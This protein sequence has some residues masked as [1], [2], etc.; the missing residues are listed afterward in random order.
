[1]RAYATWAG[2]FRTSHRYERRAVPLWEYRGRQL[3]ETRL[4]RLLLLVAAAAVYLIAA[5]PW[6]TAPW[7]M[8]AAKHQPF[9][10]VSR[11]AVVVESSVAD[12]ADSGAQEP[13]RMIAA[14][15]G[16]ASVGALGPAAVTNVL[17][18][19]EFLD[20][21]VIQPGE[22]LS[23]DDVAR[24]WDFAEDPRYVWGLATSRF[25]FISM[26]GGGVCWV[27]TALWRASLAAGL[28]TDHRQSHYGLVESLGPGSDATNT[29]V[30]RNDTGVPI[31]VRAWLDEEDVNVALFPD[32]PLD[33]TGRIRGPEPVGRGRYV[34]YQDILWAD[35]RVTSTPFQTGYFW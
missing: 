7:R 25:G 21:F 29:L 18:A 16:L 8:V 10:E 11:T 12:V 2:T 17:I 20:G 30:I 33:R 9:V 27:S 34:M 32:E 23:F 5:S 31:T 35:R 13:A 28:R 14:G 3:L 1:M 4:P 22:R 24:T 6:A 26:R 19:I 15:H